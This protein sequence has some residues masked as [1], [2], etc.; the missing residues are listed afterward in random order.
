MTTPGLPVAAVVV[1]T[2][3]AH[4]DRE[5]E[6]AVP[7]ELD[8]SARPGVAVRVRFAGRELTGFVVARRATAGHSGTLTSIR[9][10]VS[11]EPVL[12]PELL[13]LCRRVARHYGGT[14]PDVI[15]LAI[16]KRHAR[17]EL[18]LTERPPA[19]PGALRHA[20]GDPGPWRQYPAGP[21][22]LHRVAAGE[23][24]AASWLAV[25]GAAPEQDWPQALAVAAAWS[26]G[27][28]RGV[29]IVLPDHRD[30]ARV[31][32]ALLDV[33]GPGHH[34]RLTADQGPQAR[35]TAWL[36]AARGHVRCVVGTRAAAFAPVANLGLVAWWDDGDDL[37]EEPRAPYPA[38][39]EVLRLRATQTGA[40]LLSGGFARSARQQLAV[41]DG[42]DRPVV[43]GPSMVRAGA[44]RVVIAGEEA[45][46]DGPAG[47]ARLPTVAWRAAV[48]A[49]R[50][51]PV[52]VQVPRRGYV[53][54]MRCQ[55]CRAP[56]RCR[57]C[58]GPLA[59]DASGSGVACRWCGTGLPPSGFVCP[60]C[61]GRRLRSSVVGARRTAEELG[62]AFPGVPVLTSG[63]GSVLTSVGS[64]PALVVATP[65][66]EPV[67]EGG[68]AA[69]LLLDGWAL[70]ERA[71]LDAGLEA[72]R[73]WMAA[74]SLSR[75][76]SAGGVALLCGTGSVTEPAVEA[77]VRWDP[78]WL[79]ASELAD[80]LPL[81]LPPTMVLARVSGDR[82]ALADLAAAS[83]EITG[84]ERFG[85]IPLPAAPRAAGEGGGD[86]A[87][88]LLRVDRGRRSELADWLAG[89]RAVRSAARSP[90]PITVRVD[91][92][93]P[94]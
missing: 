70:L 76:G 53:P 64:G 1:L 77:L 54:S 5:F 33:L 40:A 46:R 28:G 48:S 63:A 16:P 29:V 2:P 19:A 22:W 26:L 65:G 50:S 69:V 34:V 4:L 49:L 42:S 83:A 11:T 25:P 38:V 87:Q 7:A 17:A 18:A 9:A 41:A 56:G 58:A 80:R 75:P 91:V 43:A 94:D 55:D 32:A 31:D 66:A 60:H 89:A 62:R 10:V 30:V 73:R 6:Y 8:A 57:R 20:E 79:A 37:H 51:G 13:E 12:S 81:R 35:Y 24:P 39:G 47:A 74:A 92:R 61:E 85:P 27:A 84:A 68:Y 93:E 52:L 88:F 71:S 14:T 86:Q 21:S 67:A 90:G 44:P 23:S 3:L 59:L 82:Q 78:A 72:L 36:T 45:G 15:R